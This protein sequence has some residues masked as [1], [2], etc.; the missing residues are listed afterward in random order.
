MAQKETEAKI[1]RLEAQNTALRHENGLKDKQLKI[2]RKKAAVLETL[3][4]SVEG[5]V[6]P[7][8]PLPKARTL[9]KNVLHVEDV[10][11]HLS[12]EHMDE[13]VLPHS[14]QG[15]DH[16]TFPIAVA[17]AEKYVDTVLSITQR[18][19]QGYQ[20]NTLWILAYGDHSSGELH[21]S[22]ERSY[23]RNQF[24]NA[25]A[26]SQVHALMI[27]DLAPYFKDVVVVYVSGNHGRRSPKKDYHGAW[28]SWDYMIAQST[29]LLCSKISNVKFLIPDAFSINVSIANKIFAIEHGDDIPTWNSIPFYGLE[30]KSRR[31]GIINSER[32]IKVDYFVYGH[33]HSPSSLPVVGD[34]EIII[35][36][37]WKATDPYCLGKFGGYVE[38][39]QWLH[40]VHKD[41]GITWRFKVKLRDKDEKSGPKRYQVQLAKA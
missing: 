15:L 40:G 17:R 39:S 19:L 13:T 7:L 23:Y 9:K 26:I 33:F 29:E 1:M 37:A 8:T 18:S 11:M 34:S 5:V 20:F 30:R 2:Y 21:D 41:H 3:M 22:V 12:D 32:G 35:N 31:L 28:D 6:K 10:V 14:V 4:E 16:Y 24:R 38:P 27:R 25:F 36:G